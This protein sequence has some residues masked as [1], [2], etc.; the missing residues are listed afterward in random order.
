MV[1][2]S[3]PALFLDSSHQSP[4]AILK[5]VSVTLHNGDQQLDTYA[6]LD[7]RSELSIILLQA[8]ELL[9]LNAHPETLDLQTVRQDV[10]HVQGA[11]VT[12][13]ISPT[14]EPSYRYQVLSAF[15]AADLNFTEHSCPL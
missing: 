10:L 13:T 2:A 1:S 5:V 12:F 6:I 7:D 3:C 8:V 9:G 15:T 11:S 14:D 4:R